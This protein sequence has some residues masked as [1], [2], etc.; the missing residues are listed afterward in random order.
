MKIKGSIE[1]KKNSYKSIHL[2]KESDHNGQEILFFVEEECHSVLFSRFYSGFKS[3]KFPSFCCYENSF[4][5]NNL[6][7]KH[8]LLGVQGSSS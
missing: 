5:M 3:F 8:Q 7:G 4:E 6:L 2:S 1:Q